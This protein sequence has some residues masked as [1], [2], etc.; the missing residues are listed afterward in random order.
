MLPV[1]IFVADV[2]VPTTEMNP[3][4]TVQLVSGNIT[5]RFADAI[6]VI[7]WYLL[8]VLLYIRT[9]TPFIVAIHDEENAH[10]D[11]PNPLCGDVKPPD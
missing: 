11:V 2:C 6:D 8:A 4:P 10:V 5:V 9:S 7:E 1:H 3:V